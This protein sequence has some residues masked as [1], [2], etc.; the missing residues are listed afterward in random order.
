MEL[1]DKPGIIIKLDGSVVRTTKVQKYILKKRVEYKDVLYLEIQSE[2]FKEIE[3]SLK[4]LENQYLGA[5]PL[6]E[7]ICVIEQKSTEHYYCFFDFNLVGW[8][9][10]KMEDA[11]DW[12]WEDD[13]KRFTLMGETLENETTSEAHKRLWK[14]VLDTISMNNKIKEVASN[15]LKKTNEIANNP[16]YNAASFIELQAEKK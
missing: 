8:C 2:D 15:I 14:Q 3:R 1:L 16:N 12:P 9:D 4:E 13:R 10:L 5:G 11:S 6:K 7:K